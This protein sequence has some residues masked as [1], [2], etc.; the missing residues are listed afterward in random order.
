MKKKLA[1][2]VPCYNEEEVLL[3][4]HQQLQS[5]LE[6]FK[7]KDLVSE[8]SFLLYVDDGSKDKTWEIIEK[9]HQQEKYVR[10]L[11]LSN[12]RGHQN[13]LYAGLMQI[14]DTVDMSIS[15]DADLQDD[16][17]VMEEMIQ[18]YHDGADVVYG[19]RK[20]RD[21]DRFFKRFT[22]ETF[23]KLMHI[24]GAKTVYNSADYRLMSQRSMMALEMYGEANLFLR[25]IIPDLGFVT[26]KVYYARK[27]RTAG[28]SKYPLRKMISFALDGITSFSMKPL[29]LILYG[30]LLTIFLSILFLI[31]GFYRHAQGD[32]IPGWS[33]L[34]VSIWFLGGVQL[35]SLGVVGQYVGKNFMESKKRPRFLV[36]E[37]LGDKKRRM[38]KM[39]D[40]AEKNT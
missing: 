38:R 8:E 6:M 36:Q 17:A 29:T 32:T 37:Y 12:N 35:A 24:L 23:Y 14:K 7:Q 1:I 16:I 39:E 2:V 15:I 21:S 40:K 9:L 13:A 34:F 4:S 27:E 28:E 33:S 22:A 11:R 18:Q 30:G 5:Q 26:G 3:S 19:V 10:G 25:G 31:Y 20:Q